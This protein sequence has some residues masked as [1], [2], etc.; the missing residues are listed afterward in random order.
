MLGGNRVVN[1]RSTTIHRSLQDWSWA[2][3]DRIGGRL[4]SY[5][6]VASDRARKGLKSIYTC[7][8]YYVSKIQCTEMTLPTSPDGWRPI[9]AVLKYRPYRACT[10]T[11]A[12]LFAL[13]LNHRH[14]SEEARWLVRSISHAQVSSS[15]FTI[16]SNVSCFWGMKHGFQRKN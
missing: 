3:D 5:R 8:G 14:L 16:F 4:T 13:L 6:A 15:K 11:C 10:L 9:A 1:G 2:H 7:L 12:M